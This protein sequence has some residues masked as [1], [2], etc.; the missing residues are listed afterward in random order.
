MPLLGVIVVLLIAGVVL[1]M[2][3]IDPTIKKIVIALLV[4]AAILAI[5]YGFGVFEGN[6]RLG[7]RWR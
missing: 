3:P 6:P 4:I 1:A 2:F 7:W 5:A